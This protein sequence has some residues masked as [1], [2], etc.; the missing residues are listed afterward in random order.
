MQ[1][2]SDAAALVEVVTDAGDLGAYERGV[3]DVLKSRLAFEIAMFKRL[4]GISGYGVDPKVERACRPYWPQFK[5]EAQ[6]VLVAAVAQRGVAVD[7]DVLGRKKLERLSIYQRLMRPHYGTSTAFVCLTRH[8]AVASLLVLGRTTGGFDSHELDYLRALAPTLSVCDSAA[9][10][11]PIMPSTFVQGRTSLTPRE[12]EV[13]AHLRLGH[14]NG[15]IALALGT[16]E[17]TV[18][19]QLSSIYDKL[20]VGS[21]AEAAALSTEL[22]LVPLRTA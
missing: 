22:G 21:R 1:V 8:G 13:L 14:T 6:P 5:L 3:L 7:I 19:N 15:Q 9:L 16:A 20:G 2:G 17:R 4:D 18:R 12:R 11:A 10:A